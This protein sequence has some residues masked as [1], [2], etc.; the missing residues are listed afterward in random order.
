VAHF[1]FGI[2]ALTSSSPNNDRR[3]VQPRGRVF[4]GGKVVYEKGDLSYDCVIRDLTE[5]GARIKLESDAPLP[6]Q[7]HL[8]DYKKGIVHTAEIAWSTPPEHGV[9]FTR[10]MDLRDETSNDPIVKF[11]RRLWLERVAR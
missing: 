11:M 8:I 6:K 10:S 3:K 4:L 1:A 7:I 2:S 5:T 9:K